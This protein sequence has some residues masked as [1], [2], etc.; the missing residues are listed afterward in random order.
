[1]SQESN[2]LDSLISHIKNNPRSSTASQDSDT[3]SLEEKLYDISHFHKLNQEKENLSSDIKLPKKQVPLKKRQ[4]SGNKESIKEKLQ[5]RT[6]VKK[7][8]DL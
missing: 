5:K 1:M 8:V 4:S 7:E 6:K 3:A 2:P